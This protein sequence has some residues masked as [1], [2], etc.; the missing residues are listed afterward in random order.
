MVGDGL[1]IPFVPSDLSDRCRAF[2]SRSCAD[3]SRNLV[4]HHR[5]YAQSCGKEALVT[6]IV[7]TPMQY[8]VTAFSRLEIYRRAFSWAFI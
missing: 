1:L 7:L 2:K 4:M 3:L 6:I 5:S 8:C